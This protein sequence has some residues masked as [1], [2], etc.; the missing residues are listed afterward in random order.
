MS[1][2]AKV[3]NGRVVQVIKAEP[4]FFTKFKDTSPG[5]W[6]QT[7]FNTRSNQHIANGTPLRGNF[8]GV[9]YIYDREHDVFYPPKPSETATLN[10][11]TWTWEDTIEM[12]RAS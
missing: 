6:L 11:S 5:T 10:T 1:H 8:A 12:V 4:E 2:Y 9:G 7:S 3:L